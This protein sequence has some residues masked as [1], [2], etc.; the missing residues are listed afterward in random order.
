MENRELETDSTQNSK[1]S[2]PTCDE[3]FSVP[4]E[5]NHN[6]RLID[7]YL[8]Y[9]LKELVNCVKEFDFQY[10]DIKDAEMALLIDMLVDARDVYSQRKFQL[11]QTRQK[12]HVTPKPDV[13][14]KQQRPS[15]AP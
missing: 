10:S 11:G 2:Q 8:Q 4:R 5:K 9:Q 7:L 14:L 1:S 12:I 15:K 6:N 3:Q 13:E